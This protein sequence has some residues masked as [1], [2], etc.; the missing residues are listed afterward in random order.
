MIC[1]LVWLFVGAATTTAATRSDIDEDND[2]CDNDGCNEEKDEDNDGYCD[3]DGDNDGCDN[4]DCNEDN[5]DDNDGFGDSDCTA[6]LAIPPHRMASVSIVS[7]A[8]TYKRAAGRT[9]CENLKSIRRSDGRV[10]LLRQ[11][12]LQRGQ[13]R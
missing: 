10:A 2:G 4:D 12:R 7:R 9:G 8:E 5:D 3:N 13:R 6:R 1:Q 11:R